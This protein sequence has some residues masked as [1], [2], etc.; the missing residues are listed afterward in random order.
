MKPKDGVPRF[1]TEA[2][3]TGIGPHDLRPWGEMRGHVAWTVLDFAETTCRDR[4][5]RLRLLETF[6]DDII[7]IVKEANRNPSLDEALNMGDGTYKP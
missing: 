6:T 7:R 4:A 1:R 3:G 5:A 2:G